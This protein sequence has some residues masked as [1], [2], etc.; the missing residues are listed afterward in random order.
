MTTNMDT[1][2]ELRPYRNRKLHFEGVLIDVI[3]PNSQ[4]KLNSLTYGLVFGSVYA[5]NEKIELD[6]VVIKMNKNAYYGSNVQLFNR[7]RFSASVETYM[8]VIK[9]EGIPAQTEG[10][11]LVRPHRIEVMEGS[12][13]QQPTRFVRNRF[14]RMTACNTSGIHNI[15]EELYNIIENLKNNGDVEEFC[16]NYIR[17]LQ[18]NKVTKHDMINTLYSQRHSHKRRKSIS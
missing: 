8:K 1:R 10:F 6:H 13:L 16:E 9:I 2:E 14:E 3:Q 17:G 4:N 15:K 12:N 7:Y 11:M 18:S 5:P